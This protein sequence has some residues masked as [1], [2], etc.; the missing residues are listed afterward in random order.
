MNRREFTTAV[1]TAIIK[2]ATN[3]E[4]IVI[5]EECG[6][7]TKKYQ[8]DHT[9]ADGLEVDK[10]RRLTVDDGKLLCQDLGRKSCHGQKTATDVA[11][12]AK[13]KR[14]EA[15]KLGAKPA[16]VKAIES[17]PMPRSEKQVERSKREPKA[18][19]HG[20]SNIARRFATK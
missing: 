1:R 5:C 3:P 10:R 4:S 14:K 2:R 8:I 20:L 15:A 16:P 19:V 9:K 18:P 17:A 12:I 11:V 6:L 7:P 13:A